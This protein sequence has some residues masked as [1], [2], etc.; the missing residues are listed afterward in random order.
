MKHFITTALCATLVLG[1][2]VHVSAQNAN[3]NENAQGDAN[4]RN[5]NATGNGTGNQNGK[6]DNPGRSN[7]LNYGRIISSLNNGTAENQ[8]DAFDSAESFSLVT[9]SSLPGRAAENANALS[10]ALET[11]GQSA[12]SLQASIEENTALAE[13]IEATGIEVDQIIGWTAL[14]DG[15]IIL[16]VDDLT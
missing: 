10:I 15:E 12:E 5:D 9:L 6:P 8:S 7:D 11:S 16:I 14:R 2:A 13:A 3:A 1:S 4:A